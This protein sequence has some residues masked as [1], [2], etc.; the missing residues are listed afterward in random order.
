MFLP[1]TLGVIAMAYLPGIVSA[2]VAGRWAVA[3][4]CAALMLLFFKTRPFLGPG[5][6]WAGLLLI[7]AALSTVW[8]VSP[9]D[10]LGELYHWVTLAA[11]FFLASQ[12]NKSA[13]NLLLAIVFGL[14]VSVPFALLQWKGF[15]PVIATD[16]PAS[17]SGLFLSKNALGEVSAM[18]LVW[19][20]A[21]RNWWCMPAP[22][23]LVLLSGSRGALLGIFLGLVYLVPSWRWRVLMLIVTLMG[24]ALLTRLH[25]I[26]MTSIVQHIDIWAV[27]IA[28]LTW[29]GYGLNT[30]GTLIP[31]YEFSHNDTI[32]LLFELGPIGVFLAVMLF[33]RAVRRCTPETCALVALAGASL[34]S[35]PLHHPTGAVLMAVLSGYCCGV[36]DR[37]SRAKSIIRASYFYRNYPVYNPIP[38]R[39][40]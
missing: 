39:G 22:L 38:T 5:H 4:I 11:L 32:Q 13:D 6:F 18:T 9:F 28:N 40:L 14:F 7:W 17:P 24:F 36:S 10:S 21:R 16:V 31:Q 19:A 34:V 29:F 8:S 20:I 3:S 30:F 2:T 25:D 26:G 23:L 15:V 35:F 27:T 37:T 1:I 12:Y 33:V